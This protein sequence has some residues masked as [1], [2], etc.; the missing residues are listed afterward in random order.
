MPHVLLAL[1]APL[2]ASAL[3]AGG[4]HCLNW[5][6]LS[7]SRVQPTLDV[8]ICFEKSQLNIQVKIIFFF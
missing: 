4:S 1:A 2:L 7:L 5:S 6:P 8:S 3:E